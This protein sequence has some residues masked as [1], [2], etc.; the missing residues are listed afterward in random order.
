MKNTMRINY[1]IVIVITFMCL[2]CKTVQTN[3]NE[4]Q[5]NKITIYSK[6]LEKN[7]NVNVYLP[8]NYS[9]HKKYP[10]LYMLHGYTD[11]ENCWMP[12]LRLQETV[13][14][15][16]NENRINPIIIIMPQIDNSFGINTDKIANM[17]LSFSAGLYEDYLYKDIIPY[18]DKHYSTIKNKHGRYIGGL[19]M[20]GFAALHLAFIHNN[21]FSKVGGHSPAFIEDM[22]LYPNDY[23]RNIRD[24]IR[25]AEKKDLG[26]LKV[27]LDCG[28]M[29]SFE[30]YIGCEQL[31]NILKQKNITCEY[32]LNKGE[33][34]AQYWIDNSEKYLIFYAG[35]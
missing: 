34:N 20:G 32:H 28:D 12:N 31:F 3:S 30:F 4:S 29:D 6:A 17:S 14:K 16:I 1:V 10:V 25:I 2:S 33:H 13:D 9:K 22:W 7:M 26:S 23:I 24:P 35:K 21:M 11:N 27:Y 5:V 15:L 8:T 18:V 19:S